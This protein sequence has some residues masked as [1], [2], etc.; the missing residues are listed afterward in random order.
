MPD[1]KEKASSISTPR[2]QTVFEN[3]AQAPTQT[4]R[5]Q[6]TTLPVSLSSDP[7]GNRA[8]GQ[9]DSRRE[10]TAARTPTYEEIRFAAYQLYLER[11]SLDGFADEDWLQ[12]ERELLEGRE[13][14]Q[15]ARAKGA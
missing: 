10:Q 4:P 15:K 13:A 11:G 3:P 12:A 6:T 1:P 5:K 7:D 2:P 14:Q 8:S 9:P